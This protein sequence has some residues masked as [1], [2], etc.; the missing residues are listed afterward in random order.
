[1]TASAML[2]A[3]G[4]T[5]SATIYVVGESGTVDVRPFS[6]AADSVATLDVSGARQVWVRTTE[7]T[8]RAGLS[9]S[10][11]AAGAE[12]LF[13]LVPLPPAQV[14]ATQVPVRQIPG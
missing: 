5:A 14:S 3:T 12:P 9:L 11:N 2:V 10:L 8:V 1:A 4:G 7:G 13:A 6:I